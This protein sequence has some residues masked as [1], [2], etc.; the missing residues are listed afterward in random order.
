M[1]GDYENIGTLRGRTGVPAEPKLSAA[2]IRLARVFSQVYPTSYLVRK[3]QAHTATS[4]V[5]NGRFGTREMDKN[6]MCI[7]GRGRRSGAI[8]RTQFVEQ[9][10]PEGSAILHCK[11]LI[12]LVV[13]DRKPG[14][15]VPGGVL[16]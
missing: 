4:S 1:Y 5:P 14:A 10:S 7:D 9:F 2:Q 3:S 12:G 13:V 8:C 16:K 11:V 6:R 15:Y